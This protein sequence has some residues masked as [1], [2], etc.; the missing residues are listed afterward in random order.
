[1]TRPLQDVQDEILERL[2]AG[3]LPDRDV[4]LLEHPEH[5][6]ALRRFFALLDVVE[7]VPARDATPA[8]SG[9]LGD[10][11]ILREIGRGGMGV[12]Y[13]A[14][15][16]SLNRKVALK[17][18]PA[19][20]R[21]D[22]RLLQR[23]RREAEAAAR[24]RHP[25]LV[26][27]YALGDADGAPFF[28][29][30][31]V[32][33]RSL[34]DVIAA[35]ARGEAAGVP[36]EAG[37]FRAWAVRTVATVADALAYAHG[38]GILHRDVKPANILLEADGT[39]RLTDFGLALD[40]EASGLTLS[41]EV[42]GSPLY[43]S[44]EQAFRRAQPLDAR[45]DVYSLAVT[46]HE[47]LT[48]RLPYAGTTHGDVM[49]A[50]SSGDLVPPRDVDRTMPEALED[51]L[52]TA[53]AHEPEARYAS[54]CEFA[55]DLRASLDGGIL[56]AP[57]AA[58]G[59]GLFGRR[60]GRRLRTARSARRDAWHAGVPRHERRARRVV[61]VALVAIAIL[62]PLA[63]LGMALTRQAL[64][65]ARIARTEAERA[66]QLEDANLEAEQRAARA[67]SEAEGSLDE[68][69]AQ[70][71]VA[72]SDPDLDAAMRAALAPRRAE[73]VQVADT[74]EGRVLHLMLEA[75]RAGGPVAAACVI[76]LRTMLG[77]SVLA[78]ARVFVP[79][80]DDPAS[81][82]DADGLQTIVVFTSPHTLP[83]VA[84]M[85]LDAIE[86]GSVDS[87]RL[88]YRPSPD[89]AREAG[90]IGRYWG[91]DMSVEVPLVVEASAGR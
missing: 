62:V 12:V 72:V 60:H 9:R 81:S 61:Q 28:A 1:M 53:L 58:S 48:G 79:A 56:A 15:Q 54:A 86:H 41:G 63:F 77:E 83:A 10:F 32:E 6:S 26:P 68:G 49:A 76:E 24:L 39:P 11:E 47:L 38:Q 46:L 34:A 57:R 84:W 37:D 35:R 85:K 22:R 91:G 78:T 87:L 43:M 88:T 82:P 16:L 30:E 67:A 36:S 19:A 17:V 50:L 74:S 14:R 3:D 45:T 21:G 23:F 75:P 8:A 25:N 70:A 4:L 27:V 33:G 71:P 65:S 20:S 2:H 31:L 5:A 51:V 64:D 29:M 40:L 44:P 52:L 42:F 90:A 7:A 59:S 89:V 13:E 66:R 73:V 80:A 69:D 18:L 55:S